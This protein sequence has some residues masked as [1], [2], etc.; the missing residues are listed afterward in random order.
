MIVVLGAPSPGVEQ[1]VRGA[2]G[3]RIIASGVNTGTAA[4]LNLGFDLA[5]APFVFA[6]HEDTELR[7]G[8]VTRLLDTARRYPRAG[9]I[10]TR[11]LN[12]DSSLQHLGAALWGTADL[13]PL[14]E[15]TAPQLAGASVPF[16]VGITAASAMFVR[17]SAWEAI[18]GYDERYFP[19]T[20]VD[21]DF[22]VAMRAHGYD[23]LVDPVATTTHR[24]GASQAEGGGALSSLRFRDWIYERHRDRL[25]EKWPSVVP[26]MKRRPDGVGRSDATPDMVAR[27]LPP[28]ADAPLAGAPRPERVLTGGA[29]ATEGPIPDAIRRRML[30][31]EHAVL[32]AFAQD[33]VAESDARAGEIR[34]LWTALQATRAEEA[35]LLAEVQRL[36]AQVV[37]LRERFEVYERSVSGRRWRLRDALLRRAGR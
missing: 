17:R 7:E 25:L 34:A 22:S 18:G 12:P 20:Y 14:D 31:L 13:T 8:C 26:T 32:D 19:F 35:R 29:V 27:A 9:A 15:R 36:D 2:D 5:R 23:V 24:R 16:R 1:V 30:E 21:V 28:P 10:G 3:V 33:V 4:A 11:V 6:L 37:G